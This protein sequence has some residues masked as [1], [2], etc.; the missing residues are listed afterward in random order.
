MC[1]VRVDEE[2][3]MVEAAAELYCQPTVE[4]KSQVWKADVR[5]VLEVVV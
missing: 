4:F 5:S 3:H 2:L 1:G